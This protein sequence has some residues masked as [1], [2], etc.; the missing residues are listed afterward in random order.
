MAVKL[1]TRQFEQTERQ[2]RNVA[3]V[4]CGMALVG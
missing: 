3:P 4:G 1:Y 2:L